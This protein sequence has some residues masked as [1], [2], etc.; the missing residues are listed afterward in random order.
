MTELVQAVVSGLVIGSI[1]ALMTVGMTLIYGTLRTLNMA[2]GVMVMGGGYVA[3]LAF[4]K[5]GL[6]P[7]L[8]IVL[9][10][11][12]T[13]AFGLALHQVAVRP[14]IGRPGIDLEM[15][16]FIATLA[17]AIVLQNAALLIFGARNKP[18]PPLVGGDVR[19]F[20]GVTVSRHSILMGVVAL[21]LLIALNRFLTRSRHGLAIGAVAQELSAARLMGI[22]AGRV[23]LLTMALASALAGIA[24]VLLA[25]V[26]FVSPNSGDLPLLKALIVAIFGGLGSV[27]GTIVAA[28]VIGLL[29]SAVSLYLGVSWSLPLLFAFIMVV[30]TVRP[31]GLYGRPQEARL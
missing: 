2:H 8:G 5:A 18:F 13:F 6:D 25:S 9:G 23:Y 3:W 19:L 29:E 7:A 27:R 31:N 30:L 28:F 24:G 1:Y 12:V 14:L 10:F 11:V 20:E 26:Y 21:A 4:A 16:G 15:T 17:V 22:N